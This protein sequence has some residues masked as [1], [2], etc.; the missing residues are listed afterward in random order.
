MGK[1]DTLE[2]YILLFMYSRSAIIKPH[3]SAH[4]Y[5]STF[6]EALFSSCHLVCMC[7]SYCGVCVCAAESTWIGNVQAMVLQCV[8]FVEVGEWYVQ[9]T[10]M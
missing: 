4:F 5:V 7:M 10:V 8:T 2:T 6:G 9:F 3:S 1:H